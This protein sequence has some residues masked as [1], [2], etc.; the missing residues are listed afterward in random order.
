MQKDNS[1]ANVYSKEELIERLKAAGHDFTLV[2]ADTSADR[3]TE[4]IQEII[5]KVPSWI[6]RWGIVLFFS[7][8]I[9]FVGIAQLIKYPEILAADL[10]IKSSKMSRAV[11][12][13]D[14]GVIT[15]VF[16]DKGAEVQRGQLLACVSPCNKPNETDSLIAPQD[17]RI[18]F[19]AIMQRGAPLS[20]NQQVFSI[21][22]DTK[23]FF[24]V[25]KIPSKNINKIR[26]GQEV[27][28]EFSNYPSQEYGL[29]KG[30]IE[31][32]ADEPINGQFFI[33][34][35]KFYTLQSEK[36]LELKEWMTGNAKILIEDV[37]IFQRITNNIFKSLR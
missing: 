34:K 33:V 1:N 13:V 14:A 3:H 25:V 23:Q 12:N 28:I 8:L 9:I 27:L 32:I 30:K 11:M 20:V 22:P 17:G 5:T 7:I 18:S 21:S 24:G 6:L 37:S 16:I 4:E 15:K 19:A 10:E 26:Q 2:V 31:Y 29:Q 35:V 36:Q